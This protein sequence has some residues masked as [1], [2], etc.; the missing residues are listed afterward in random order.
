V[1]YGSNLGSTVG[2]TK[3]SNLERSL[4]R[5]PV[6]LRSVFIGIILSDA[7]I[8]KSNVGG[9]DRLQFKQK[10]SQLEYLYSVFFELSHY[11][12]QGPSVNTTIV[13]KKKHYA[14]SF[15]TRNLP[16]ITDL[17]DLFYAAPNPPKG[18]KTEGKKRI[19]HNIYDL[20]T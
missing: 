2:Y 1:P 11:C 3:F 6:G 19:P 9:D 7:A 10:Y 5:I 8:Q 14:L 18:D 15:T 12:S 13:H 17:Y 4:I 16:C 20:L